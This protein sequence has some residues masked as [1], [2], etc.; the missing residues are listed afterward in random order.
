MSNKNPT[1]NVYTSE[2]M[3]LSSKKAILYRNILGL[4]ISAIIAVAAFILDNQGV[5]LLLINETQSLMFALCI[6][7]SCIGGYYVLMLLSLAQI[8]VK[9]GGESEISMLGR[10]YRVLTGFALLIGAAYLLGKLDA[11]TSFFTLFGGMLLGWS[12]QAPVSGFAAWVM[13]AMS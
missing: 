12:L 4:V 1:S 3:V 10:F 11:F 7:F 8:H 5:R 9:R 2:P 13:V 6:L